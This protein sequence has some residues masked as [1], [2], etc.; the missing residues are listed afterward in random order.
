MLSVPATEPLD[1]GRKLTLIVHEAPGGIGLA[2]VLVSL[3]SSEP[4]IAVDET[5]SGAVPVFVTVTD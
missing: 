3:N 4:D 5:V 1:V 2:H